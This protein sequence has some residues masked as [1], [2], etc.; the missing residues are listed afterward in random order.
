MRNSLKVLEA[1]DKDVQ[2]GGTQV[3]QG[4]LSYMEK[5]DEAIYSWGWRYYMDKN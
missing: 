4:K 3:E 2:E 5:F 1:K